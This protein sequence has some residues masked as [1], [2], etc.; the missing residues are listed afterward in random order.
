MTWIVG[1]NSLFGHSYLVSDICVTFTSS[2]GKKSF[3]DCLQKVYPLGKFII[4]GFAGSVQ[5]GFSIFAV[6]QREF[7]IVENGHAW[8]LDIVAN[9]WFPKLVRRIFGTCP[10]DEQRLGSQILLATAHPHKNRGVSPWAQTD[11][12][13]FNSPDFSA[14]KAEIDDVF[15][16]GSGSHV[17]TYVDAIKKAR[18]NFSYHETI[19]GGESSQ[20]RYIAM[21]VERAVKANPT[22]GVSIFFQVAIVS[23]SKLSIVNY[24]YDIIKPG[25]IKIEVR[26]PPIARNMDQFLNIANENRKLAE[27]AVCRINLTSP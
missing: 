6:L 10:I 26:C 12:Y 9:T 20:A 11:L 16:I 17:S 27:G 8:S 22:S 3:I 18:D 7:S 25:G 14:K 1:C 21:G 13:L 5:I 24:D 4:G 15:C 2:S 23:R 19:Y